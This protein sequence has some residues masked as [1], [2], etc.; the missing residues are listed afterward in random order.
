MRLYTVGEEE[1]RSGNVTDVYFKRTADTLFHLG[2]KNLKVRMEF[3]CYGLPK[4][5]SWGVFA[6]LEEALRLLEG[7]NVTVY[8]M[9]EGTIFRE[10]EPVMIIEGDYLE[11]GE[12]ETAL[13]GVLRHE[14]SIATKAA[15]IKMLALNKQ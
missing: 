13:L 9:D 15:R 11:F 10:I 14:S 4:G 7:R 12:L 2:I 5:Y 3:H 6:G 1:I 8:A